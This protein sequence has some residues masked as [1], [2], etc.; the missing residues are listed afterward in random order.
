MGYGGGYRI[1]I[2]GR[3]TPTVKALLIA[4]GAVFVLQIVFYSGHQRLAPGTPL[5]QR[6]SWFE[7]WFALT[8]IVAIEGLRIWQFITYSF[9]HDVGNLFHILMNMFILW[10]FGGD[11]ESMLGRRR[12]LWL[13]FLAALAGGLCMIPWYTTP[14]LGASAAVFGVMAMYARLFPQRRVFIWGILPVRARTLVIGLAVLD[15]LAAAQGSD[16]GVANLAHVGG[17]VV[18]WFFLPLAY[19]FQQVRSEQADRQT[20][21]RNVQDAATRQRVDQLLAKIGRD[22]L[23]SLT[24]EEREFLARASKRPRE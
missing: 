2:G 24:R 8:P 21:R 13:Y 3:L 5:F 15:L 6:L 4:N 18:G 17:F 14:I 19:L 10:M 20:R 9:L 1:R 7:Q 11:V 23:G 22:G 16:T 12:F